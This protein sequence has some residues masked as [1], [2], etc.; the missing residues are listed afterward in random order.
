MGAEGRG[1]GSAKPRL[2]PRCQVSTSGP[3]VDLLAHRC[4]THSSMLAHGSTCTSTEYLLQLHKKEGRLR[5][6]FVASL[7]NVK[8]SQEV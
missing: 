1:A 6:P 7:T 4:A 3:T 8:V 2:S 5:P